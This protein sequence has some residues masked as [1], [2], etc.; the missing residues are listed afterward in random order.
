MEEKLL[1]EVMKL[2]ALET[3]KQMSLI[4]QEHTKKKLLSKPKV[5]SPKVSHDI[6]DDE[7]AGERMIELTLMEGEIGA[8]E[9]S[10]TLD[11]T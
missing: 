8:G 6:F 9:M 7:G 11:K 3:Q 1:R 5:N 2:S 10:N 4:S